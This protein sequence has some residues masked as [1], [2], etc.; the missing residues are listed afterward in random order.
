M[1]EINTITKLAEFAKSENRYETHGFIF[2]SF[3]HNYTY[4]TTLLFIHLVL[5]FI[6]A[7]SKSICIWMEVLRE[8]RRMPCTCQ[9]IIYWHFDGKVIK[10]TYSAVPTNGRE[11]NQK[12]NT[13][14]SR[15]YVRHQFTE[16]LHNFLSNH[17]KAH[18]SFP[19]KHIWWY[20]CM[21]SACLLKV[22]PDNWG[23]TVR[24]H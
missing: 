17:A 23:S 3:I 12:K 19:S 15:L 20:Q 9:W 6:I 21:I 10:I 5:L 2:N 1:H 24:V 18:S 4:F 8:I 22:V 14:G 7:N 13:E 11:E 16:L